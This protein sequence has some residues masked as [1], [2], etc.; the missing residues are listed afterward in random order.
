MTETITQEPT[1]APRTPSELIATIQTSLHQ[2]QTT[3]AEA[4]GRTIEA[5]INVAYYGGYLEG[6]Q[7][8]LELVEHESPR[9]AAPFSKRQK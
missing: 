7:A 5:E 4:Q 8:T 2:W 3:L 6:I 9:F 1:P